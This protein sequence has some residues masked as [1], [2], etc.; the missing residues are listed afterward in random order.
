VP[1]SISPINSKN[2]ACSANRS[3]GTSFLDCCK[4]CSN[5]PTGR[6]AILA[7]QSA[8][9]FPPSRATQRGSEGLSRVSAEW[10]TGVT[11]LSGSAS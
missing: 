1:R 9:V 3:T 11:V 5:N 6:R 2:V 7:R 8:D 4:T 10:Q